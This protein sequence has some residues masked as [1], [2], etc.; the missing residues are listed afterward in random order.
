M[1]KSKGFTLI[2]L[3]NVVAIIAI[4]AA[5]AIPNLLQARM[6]SNESSAVT[7]LRK[8]YEA[9]QTFK[10]QKNG[11]LPENSL[12][13]GSTGYADNFS[14][15][16]SGHPLTTGSDGRPA[17]D[18]GRAL[19]LIEKEFAA[20]RGPNGIPFHGYL[21]AE[22]SGAGDSDVDAV[23]DPATGT[24]AVDPGNFWANRFAL[25]AVPSVSGRTGTKAFYIDNNGVLLMKE[26]S[27]EVRADDSLIM[28][29]PLK[30][31]SD[32]IA[33]GTL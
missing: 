16:H 21:F 33:K 20:A 31:A 5:I 1:R 6:R 18:T 25:I 8:Y 13:G 15:L 3:I 19:N 27:V 4:I 10:S 26:L 17:P 24:A 28:D 2:E 29:T 14:L 23:I 12:R 7:L 22:P 30:N 9:Q 32:W 11:S